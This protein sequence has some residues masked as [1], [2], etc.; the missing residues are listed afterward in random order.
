MYLERYYMAYFSRFL[1][2]IF[3]FGFSGKFIRWEYGFP[4][5]LKRSFTSSGHQP[6]LTENLSDKFL[7]ILILKFYF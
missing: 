6:I 1:C 3:A 7:Q 5:N 4:I 2:Y